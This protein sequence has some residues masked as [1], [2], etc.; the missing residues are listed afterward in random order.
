[1]RPSFKLI[2]SAVSLAALPSLALAESD[3]V[4]GAGSAS[5]KLDF[6]ITI[7]RVL[8][9][10]VGTG[11]FGVDVTTVDKIDFSPTAT[12]VINATSPISGTGGDLTGG[13]VTARL[14][15]NDGQISLTSSTLGALNNGGSDTISWS[16][17]STTVTPISGT[18]LAHPTLADTGTPSVNPT[19]NIG[20]KVTN[21]QSTW[22][23]AY[24]NPASA[25]AGTYGGVNTR[26]GRVTYTA[27]IP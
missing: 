27:A 4:V 9:L 3:I 24:S 16:Q 26:N 13:A 1:M 12:E 17:I 6:Q 21:L 20:T 11:T 22:T 2:V 15:G 10:Q 18:T 7:P 23:Y 8:F 14:F 25:A 5:A 19:I